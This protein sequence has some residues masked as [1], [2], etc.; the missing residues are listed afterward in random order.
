MFATYR[1]HA[2]PGAALRD[3]IDVD[4]RATVRAE[5]NVRNESG[6]GA[7]TAYAVCTALQLAEGRRDVRRYFREQF[8]FRVTKGRTVMTLANTSRVRH[9]QRMDM[10]ARRSK[11]TAEQWQ[12][13][14]WRLIALKRLL[15]RQAPDGEPPFRRDSRNCWQPQEKEMSVCTRRPS[16][17]EGKRPRASERQIAEQVSVLFLLKLKWVISALSILGKTF[18]LSRDHMEANGGSTLLS[19]LVF[20]WTR[21]QERMATQWATTLKSCSGQLQGLDIET[22]T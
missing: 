6:R 20:R 4:A 11:E 18:S 16:S 10:A 1:P 17:P 21:D 13:G 9:R 7:E 12:Q 8:T 22:V 15:F 19:R 14:T 3:R 5:V 2:L